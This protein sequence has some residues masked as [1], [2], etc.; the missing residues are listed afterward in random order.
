MKKNKKAEKKPSL[1]K[2]L[3]AAAAA[4]A[5]L[6]TWMLPPARKPKK[7]YP[8]AILLGCP[9]RRDGSMSTSQ[10]LRCRLAMA[11][12]SSYKTL[13]ITG[14]A[15]K[16]QWPEAVTMASYIEERCPIPV[17]VEDKSRTTW[18]NLENVRQIIGDV[19]VLLLTSSLHA[20]R[21]QAM[22]RHFFSDVAVLT[23]REVRLKHILREMGSRHVYLTTELKKKIV[24]GSK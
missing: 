15:V 20:P 7:Q 24:P 10:V 4:V 23:Y 8:F 17:M 5:I 16:N 19:P 13:V 3:L 2:W 11:A 22:A 6:Y 21:A 1:L 9:C 14:G 12:W 18:E